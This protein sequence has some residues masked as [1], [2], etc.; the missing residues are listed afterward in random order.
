M[1]ANINLLIKANDFST[2]AFYIDKMQTNELNFGD[3]SQFL[4]KIA[5]KKTKE[6]GDNG[7]NNNVK[8]KLSHVLVGEVFYSE[9]IK[10]SSV[11]S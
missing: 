6:G 8:Q 5:K 11:T 10:F 3:H 2:V 7:S 1:V 9:E 4:K